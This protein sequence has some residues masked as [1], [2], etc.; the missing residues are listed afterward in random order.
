MIRRFLIFG[1]SGDLTAR[2]LVPALA[3]LND[4]G[5]LP[6]DFRVHGLARDPWTTETF[7]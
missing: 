5:Q 1:A 4:A 2:F 7:R 3:S 6:G